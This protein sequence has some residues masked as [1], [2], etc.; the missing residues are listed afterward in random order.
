MLCICY[1]VTSRPPA[2]G[3]T[4]GGKGSF[5]SNYIFLIVSKL[6][7]N[8]LRQKNKQCNLCAPNSVGGVRE[9]EQKSKKETVSENRRLLSVQRNPGDFFF[10]RRRTRRKFY[11]Y[12]YVSGAH[13]TN[14]T[15]GTG[16]P[17]IRTHQPT[18]RWK[19]A[20]RRLEVFL[21]SLLASVAT[22]N[23]ARGACLAWLDLTWLCSALLCSG[24]TDRQTYGRMDER[25]LI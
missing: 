4:T 20:G 14:T 11:I 1:F 10:C 17:A 25:I 5:Y 7:A 6:G 19:A 3:P 2:D 12:I 16:K 13:T 23:L 9:R 8:G 15:T 18:R 24:Q 21:C 22:Q